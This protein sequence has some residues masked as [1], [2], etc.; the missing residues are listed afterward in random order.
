MARQRLQQPTSQTQRSEFVQ[1]DEGVTFPGGVMHVNGNVQRPERA[2][3]WL[4]SNEITKYTT[5][6]WVD[7]ATGQKRTSCNCRG[8]S[9]KKRGKKRECMH[10]KEMEGRGTCDRTPVTDEEIR[11]LTQARELIPDIH[12]GKELR[13]IM[14]D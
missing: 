9:T 14:L 8:W 6:T 10:T 11:T 1:S 3:H 2:K 12:D 7:P 4:S 5:I 13:G